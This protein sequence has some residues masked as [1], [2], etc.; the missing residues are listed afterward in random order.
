MPSTHK[1]YQKMY[2]VEE[3]HWWYKNLHLLV[4]KTIKKQFGNDKTI[5]IFDAGCGT[6]GMLMVLKKEGY[7]NIRGVDFSVTAVQ[8][9]QE[10]GLDVQQGDVGELSQFSG[11]DVLIC[12]DVLCYFDDEK[13]NQILK[14]FK[15]ILSPNGI[16][17][18]NNNAFDIF[19]GTHDIA[20]KSKRRFVWNYFDKILINN[21]LS[22]KKHTYWTLLLSPLVLLIRLKQRFLHWVFPKNTYS[23]DI[24][25]VSS[26]LNDL[27]FRLVSFE[28]NILPF[29]PFGSSLFW[30]A[31]KKDNAK[32]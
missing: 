11:I 3:K 13:I 2:E 29:Q 12:N 26:W 18:S 15:S 6:G 22:V 19:W 4:L 1:E 7:L 10:R 20:I 32:Y 27:L 23:S 25:L 21:D 28:Q 17:I 9:S 24:E 31:H 5:K 8:F 16:I 30:I 14:G